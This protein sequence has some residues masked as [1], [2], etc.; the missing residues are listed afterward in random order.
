MQQIPKPF[1]G[2]P[3]VFK[4]K[5]SCVM[6]NQ[7]LK[8]RRTVPLKI[9]MHQVKFHIRKVCKSRWIRTQ[10]GL[11]GLQDVR[12]STHDYLVNKSDQVGVQ[13]VYLYSADQTGQLGISTAD[14]C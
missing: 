5:R 12:Q 11:A 2:M 13:Y 9:L 7:S 10:Q 3:M 4:T 6:K 8:S 1:W 14:S